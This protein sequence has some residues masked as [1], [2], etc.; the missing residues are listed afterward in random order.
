MN[1]SIDYYLDDKTVIRIYEPEEVL[2][3]LSA[4]NLIER[5]IRRQKSETIVDGVV[6]KSEVDSYWVDSDG[7]QV[8]ESLVSPRTF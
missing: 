1:K 3:E 5:T 8:S 6:T 4:T 2:E 7:V